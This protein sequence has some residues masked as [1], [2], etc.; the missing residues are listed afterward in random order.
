MSPR[1]VC[2][3]DRGSFRIHRS[4]QVPIEE[5]DDH[6]QCILGLGNIHVVEESVKE[7]FPNVEFGLNAQFDQL[8]VSVESGTQLKTRACR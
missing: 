2:S 7:T 5:L 1:S 3:C 4:T 8:L 6:V